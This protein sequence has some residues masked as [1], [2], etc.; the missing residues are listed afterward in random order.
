MTSNDNDLRRR[1]R[2][3]RSAK[4]QQKATAAQT[5]ESLEPVNDLRAS[6]DDAGDG[7][8]SVPRRLLHDYMTTEELA[9]ELNVTPI[10]IVRWRAEKK[11]PPVT[12]IGGRVFY[13]RASVQAWLVA[14]E[15]KSA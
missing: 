5:R 1:R 11:G 2:Q 14:Q 9:D 12:W 7:R 15:Q 4:R 8:E 6:G 13:R 3:R 10:T